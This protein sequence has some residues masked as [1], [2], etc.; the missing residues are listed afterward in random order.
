MNTSKQPGISI[1]GMA[2]LLQVFDMPLSI[3][4]YRDILGFTVADQSQPELKDDC[5]WAMLRFNDAIIMLNTAYERDSRPADADQVRIAAHADTS[6]YFGCPDVDTA[7]K[8]L[9]SKGVPVKE[10]IVT[11]Y[12]WKAIY[13]SDPD[14]YMLCFHWPL[15]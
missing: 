2:P 6:V 9:L 4:F 7:Y 5:D 12:G 3:E 11:G 15:K 1:E 8:Y 13:V 10:P 14:G